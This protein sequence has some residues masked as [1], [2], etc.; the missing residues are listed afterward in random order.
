MKIALLG[1]G[2]MGKTIEEMALAK[3]H[4]IVAKIDCAE[5]WKRLENEIKQADV[6]IEFSMPQT[7]IENIYHC[8]DLHLPV[9]VGTTGWNAQKDEIFAYC[10]AHQ[11]T[12]FHASNYSIGVNLFFELNSHMA[13]VMQNYPDYHVH[14]EEVHHLQKLDKPSGTAITLAEGVLANYPK[15]TSWT[16]DAPSEISEILNIKAIREEDVFGIHE[17]FYTSD[18][19]TIEIRHEAKSRRGFAKGAL[20]AA[21]WLVGKTGVYTM[22]D[23]LNINNSK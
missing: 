22:S 13:R 8:F 23:L 17:I 11:N 2:K 5:D 15:K 1:Y 9:V 21:E 16:C 18:E 4:T 12:L 7:V 10:K 14:V 19:D 3:G 20:L 6:A